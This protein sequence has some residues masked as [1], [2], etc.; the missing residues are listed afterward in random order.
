MIEAFRGY[1]FVLEGCDPRWRGGV[2]SC[3]E[4]LGHWGSASVV[5]WHRPRFPVSLYALGVGEGIDVILTRVCMRAFSVR[6][7]HRC[8]AA[9]EIEES[10]EQL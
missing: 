2:G 7:R 9:V 8:G 6:G 10:E 3:S 1:V 5:V 4:V